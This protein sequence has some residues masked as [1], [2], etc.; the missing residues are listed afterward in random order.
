MNEKIRDIIFPAKNPYEGFVHNENIDLTGW[1]EHPALW[2]YFIKVIINPSI[3][4]EVGT[5][6]GKTSTFWSQKIKAFGMNSQIICIDTWLGGLE[7]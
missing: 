6:L 1:S 7:L 2:E 4:I 3:V 5:Y